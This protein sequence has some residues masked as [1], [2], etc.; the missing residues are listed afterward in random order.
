VP[1]LADIDA[2]VYTDFLLHDMGT[3]LADGL[4]RAADV[5][6]EAGSFDW[7]T[8][9]LIGLRFNRTFMHDGRAN[10]V[11]EAIFAHRGPG[12]EA[13]DAV[14]R[15]EALSDPDRTRLVDFVEAL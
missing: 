6:G 9:P 3:E 8:A 10:T 15:F 14:D 12:S 4:P 7:R 2:P 5:D 11:E 13:N 1:Q